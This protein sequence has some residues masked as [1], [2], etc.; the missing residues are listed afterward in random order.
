MELAVLAP[1]VLLLLSFAIWAGRVQIADNGV[2]EA[3]RAA[4]RAASLAVDADTAVALATA[5]AQ[6]T[7]ARQDLRCQRVDVEVDSAGLR[8]PIGQ[9]GDVTVAITCTVSMT[10]LLAPGL[11]G[12]V[13]VSASFASPVD[14]YRER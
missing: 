7:L 10:D 5:Q 13:Q 4:S 8:A 11:P 6:E 2:Q 12:S 1:A 14:A 3:A 9:S